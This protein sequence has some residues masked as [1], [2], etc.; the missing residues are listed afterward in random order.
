[1]S[2]WER[3]YMRRRRTESDDIADPSGG[4]RENWQWISVAGVLVAIAVFR[5]IGS[6]DK[7]QT[8]HVPS[9]PKS[10]ASDERQPPDVKDKHPQDVPRA[11]SHDSLGNPPAER[12]NQETPPAVIDINTATFEELD[13]LPGI[14]PVTAKA[15]IDNRPFSSVEDLMKIP[16]MSER[17]IDRFRSAVQCVVPKNQP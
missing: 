5:M 14:G 6:S 1:M 17:R 8:S 3:D 13:R 9:Q 11:D 7:P 12:L 10:H 4:G 15:I 16:R 2:L